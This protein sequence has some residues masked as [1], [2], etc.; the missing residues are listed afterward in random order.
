MKKRIAAAAAL[1]GLALLLAACGANPTTV[2]TPVIQEIIVTVEVPVE[3]TQIVE[4]PVTVE[5]AVNIP[6][7]AQ[8]AG[9]AH[10]DAAAE[11]FMHWNTEDPAEVPAGCAKCHTTSGYRDFVGADGSAP[12]AVDGP[13]AIGQVIT[14]EACHNDATQAMT[15]VTFPSG[16]EITNL[17]P[18]ARCM[19]CHQGRASGLSVEEAISQAGLTDDDTV[20]ADL[21]FTNIHYFAAAVSRYGTQVK[22]GYEYAEQTYDVLFEHVDGLSACTD[23]HNAHTLELQLDKCAACHAVGNAEDVRNIRMNGSLV[24][25]DGDGDLAEGM[26]YE[27]EGVRAKLFAGMQAYASEV[28]G[29]ALVYDTAAYPYFF[30]DTNANGALDDG[31]NNFGN[32]FTGWTGRLAKAAYNYQTSL[33]DPGAYAH[34]GK[35]IIE[36]LYDSLTDLNSVL[37]APVDMT[38]MHRIDAGHFAGSTEPFRH[39][40]TED[41][42]EV[43]GACAKCHSADGLPTFLKNGAT[44]AVPPSNGF[45]CSTCHNDLTTFT[46]YPVDSVRFP[47]GATV[48]FG[49]GA[50]ANL[51]IN[52]HQGRESTVS[53]NNAIRT[54]GVGN[55]E[56]SEALRFRNVHYFAAGATLF[57]TEVKGAY[58]FDGQEY[59]GLN[60]H[61]DLG[62]ADCVSCHETHALEVQVEACTQ[63]HK[64]VTTVADLRTIR[65]SDV[66]YDGDGDVTEGLAS[67]IGALQDAL[68]ASLQAYAVDKG[69]VALAYSP[70]AYPY[71]FADANANGVIDEGEGGYATWTP[72][73]LRAA[74][75]YQ[76]SQKDPG[77]FAHN[78]KYILQVLYDSLVAV[79]ADASAYTRP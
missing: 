46:R 1:L 6:F 74:Y 61:G 66:D 54:A 67:E 34:G 51:C 3:Q 56:V 44:I 14:C 71:F 50:E 75:N 47:S 7:E 65:M 32:A 5:P 27:L 58:E 18:E 19:Q 20:S 60:T 9:S 26:Y 23:C 33:K 45:Q 8:W 25:Y 69:G 40:D 78:G 42:A 29:V 53:V 4:V 17:G 79:G 28:S 15:S 63:C 10:A 24:D 68:L 39:W 77:A 16:A 37:A 36:L 48:T 21:G 22:G 11:A 64:T 12:G 70:T 73:L 62:P 2:P 57:G 35:Y 59:L 72:S 41:P 52:C 76:Y 49:E 30:I 55:D 38:G 31:E 43:P 13:A